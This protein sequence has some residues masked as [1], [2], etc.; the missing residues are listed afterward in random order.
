[1]I[2]ERTFSIKV[3][4]SAG[5]KKRESKSDLKRGCKSRGNLRTSSFDFLCVFFNPLIDSLVVTLAGHGWLKNADSR[6][7]ADRSGKK[8]RMKTVWII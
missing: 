1:M 7:Q 2:A 6:W 8:K 3:C 5:G 4:F